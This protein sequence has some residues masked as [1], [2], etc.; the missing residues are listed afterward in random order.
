MKSPKPVFFL[1]LVTVREFGLRLVGN[2]SWPTS[3]FFLC[4]AALPLALVPIFADSITDHKMVLGGILIG[5][6]WGV[7]TSMW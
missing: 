3:A 5:T 1:S 7:E 6:E 2:L 4:K